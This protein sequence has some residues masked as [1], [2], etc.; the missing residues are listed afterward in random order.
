MSNNS[1]SGLR[2]SVFCGWGSFLLLWLVLVKFHKLGKIESWLL[3]DLDLS[4]DAAVFLQ[5]EDFSAAFFLNLFANISLNPTQIKLII[6]KID[7]KEKNEERNTYRIL[8]KSLRDDFWMV[9]VMIS[10]IFCLICFFFD[11]LE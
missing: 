1:C 5:W 10:I 11:A 4:N 6:N 8:T 7:F 9:D 3:E 2:E